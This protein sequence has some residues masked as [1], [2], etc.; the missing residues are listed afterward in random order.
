MKM[1][2]NYLMVLWIQKEKKNLQKL[3]VDYTKK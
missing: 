3:L 1:N 2:H